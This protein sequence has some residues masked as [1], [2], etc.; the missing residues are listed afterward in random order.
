M[1]RIRKRLTEFSPQK[2]IDIFIKSF[3]YD[4][5]SGEIHCRITNRIYKSVCKKGYKRC[6]SRKVD[7]I[8]YQI[9]YHRLCWFLYYGYFVPQDKFIDHIDLNKTNN[10][11]EN[12]QIVSN[13][14]NALKRD[15]I[16]KNNKSGFKG[17]CTSID[18]NQYG[19]KY[20][21]FVASINI[22]K[23]SIKIGRFKSKTLAALFY[24][25]ANRYYYKNFSKPNFEDI[26]I[27]P[28][29]IEQLRALP[30]ALHSLS[31]MEVKNKL[32]ELLE[33]CT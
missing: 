27:S 12:L 33:I 11:I 17:V 5:T 28:K 7:D 16:R 32:G 24:D 20:K 10:K 15:L 3:K 4:S 2:A 14:K 1:K 19:K 30:R 6:L 31:E 21:Y 9:V 8:E 18:I 13:E 25:S 26:K 22:N 23:K 29:S